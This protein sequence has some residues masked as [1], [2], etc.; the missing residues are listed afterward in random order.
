MS[1]RAWL[2]AL[3]MAAAALAHAG[4]D[5]VAI[6]VQDAA[7]LRAAAGESA[8]AHTLLWQGEALEV[9]GEAGEWLQVYDH[10]R[11]RGGY[12]WAANLRRYR[13]RPEAAP[14]LLAILRF[15]RETGGAEALG[16]GYAAAYVQA[17]PGAVLRSADG[18]EAI[19]ALGLFADRLARRA[20]AAAPASKEAQQRLSA[21]LDVAARY[22]V[23][24][25][26]LET[27]GR[28]RLCYDGDAFRRVLALDAT[29]A[30]KAR[31]ALVLTR[32][33]C[34]SPDAA[35]R[36][37]QLGESAALLQSIDAAALSPPLRQ[38]L[39]VRRSRV[40]AA[41]AFHTGRRGENASELIESARAD[42][43][44]VDRRK[45]SDADAAAYDQA[46]LRVNASRWA[47][48]APPAPAPAM[49]SRPTLVSRA[50][51]EGQ[52]CLLLVDARHDAAN[53]LARRCTYGQAWLAASSVNAE[54]N[55][56]AVAV[57]QTDA[58][59]ELWLFR[60]AGGKWDV[61]VLPPAATGPGAG[62]AE[63][64]GWVPGGARM[65]VAREA[66]DEGG[67][68]RA[69]EVVR[70]DTLATVKKAS[71]PASLAAFRHWQDPA[72]KRDTLL[73]R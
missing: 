38:R 18:I 36:L 12:V 3:A 70:T 25:V 1:M 39:L 26:S 45:L 32:P 51:E 56:V 64:A 23:Q 59:R 33:E 14:E 41:V 43:A 52:T 49:T 28:V 66:A 30:Q 53:P 63:L 31:A 50:G 73:L 6:V 2:A 37:A 13:L 34:E 60:K 67:V 16:L 8:K 24:I 15:L 68:R 29:P 44:L 54:G 9:R 7:P 4:E 17:A 57:Q 46:A 35:R 62:S 20:S 71:Q 69:F 27:D 40:L 10:R 5:E 22:G 48:V 21:H 61:R 42:L 58:W 72:W 55:A 65:L 19:E 47:A 11:E